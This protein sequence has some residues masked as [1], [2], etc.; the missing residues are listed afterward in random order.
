MPAYD[1]Y[2]HEGS[3]GEGYPAA[4]PQPG[5][6]SF[7]PLYPQGAE[8]PI[9]PGQNP[10]QRFNPARW[11][12]HAMS[13][14]LGIQYALKHPHTRML[15]GDLIDKAMRV[16]FKPSVP[17]PWVAKPYRGREFGFGS[18]ATAVNGA[19]TTIWEHKIGDSEMGLLKLFGHDVSDAAAWS[20]ITWRFT[21][22]GVPV[23]APLGRFTIQIGQTEAPT[24]LSLRIN[25]GQTI[26]LEAVNAAGDNYEVYAFIYGW[27]WAMPNEG[28]IDNA[29]GSASIA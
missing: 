18:S 23:S 25:P 6:A 27:S 1:R 3:L 10:N 22:D 14:A 20:A 5:I 8:T 4:H 28:D 21:V 7:Q 2:A 11:E 29:Q 26:R 13:G 24:D 15:L 9:F 17:P 19:T 16:S 12:D